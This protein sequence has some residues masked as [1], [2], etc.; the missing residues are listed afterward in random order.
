MIVAT[1]DSP[2]GPM[3]LP[4]TS[5]PPSPAVPPP[6]RAISDLNLAA[7]STAVSCAR[8]FVACTLRRWQRRE[9]ADGVAW[10]TGELVADAVRLTG[11]PD[12]DVRW[13]DAEDLALLRVRLVLLDSGIIC[14]V[15]DRHTQLP[16]PAEH[17][18][19]VC[20]RWNAYLTPV[21]RVRWGE[22]GLPA[23]EELTEHGL[24]KRTPSPVPPAAPPG[25]YDI[26]PELLRRVR[27]GLGG[28]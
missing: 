9:L 4:P 17:F 16:A 10:V 21:G 6:A 2:A 3:A 24:P 12:P 18:Q 19:A 27:D 14:E 8:L 15:A 1:A 26:D 25:R 20:T 23:H 28:L 7:T 13:V 11:F 22:V 5:T